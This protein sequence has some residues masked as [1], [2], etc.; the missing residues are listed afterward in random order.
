MLIR[1]V[2]LQFV[3]FAPIYLEVLKILGKQLINAACQVLPSMRFVSPVCCEVVNCDG[4]SL[5]VDRCLVCR[6]VIALVQGAH[7]LASR[8][9]LVRRVEEEASSIVS[10]DQIG[11]L[12]IYRW[13]GFPEFQSLL[14]FVLRYV[15]ATNSQLVRYLCT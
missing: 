12:F 11:K 14:F 8:R 2:P 9:R 13:K 3:R 7:H 6:T 1:N 15:A 4:I 5:M 10:E